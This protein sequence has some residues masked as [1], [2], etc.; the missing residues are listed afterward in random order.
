MFL[1]VVD[2]FPARWLGAAR[3]LTITTARDSERRSSP[4]SGSSTS[5]PVEHSA[6]TNV[7]WARTCLCL[8]CVAALMGVLS[9]RVGRCGST[10][11]RA[12]ATARRPLRFDRRRAPASF[13]RHANDGRRGDTRVLF[14]YGLAR[15]YRSATGFLRRWPLLKKMKQ[16]KRE[17]VLPMLDLVGVGSA[18]SGERPVVRE[19]TDADAPSDHAAMELA[20]RQGVCVLLRDEVSGEGF[21]I[22]ESAWLMADGRLVLTSW[23]QDDQLQWGRGRSFSVAFRALPELMDLLVRNGL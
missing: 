13:Q 20:R 12:G 19:V 1:H 15:L 4:V 3:T 11:K 23:Q 17:G 8:G 10:G 21:R 22:Q 2:A 14:R 5:T 6:R 7:R 16:A 18:M 9:G